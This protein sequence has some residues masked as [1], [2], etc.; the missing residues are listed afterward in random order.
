MQAHGKEPVGSANRLRTGRREGAQRALDQDSLLSGTRPYREQGR[1]SWAWARGRHGGHGRGLGSRVLGEHV[2]SRPAISGNWPALEGVCPSGGRPAAG[3]S[4]GPQPG[5]SSR[6]TSW[7]EL[8]G[9]EVSV[10]DPLPGS[11]SLPCL[12]PR[13]PTNWSLRMKTWPH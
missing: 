3:S 11:A 6:W 9:Q 2:R 12:P 1:G 4:V 13:F 8:P 10:L 7:S 5:G